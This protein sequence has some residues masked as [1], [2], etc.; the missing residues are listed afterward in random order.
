MKA[1]S[2]GT[3]ESITL[4]NKPKVYV[5]FEKTTFQKINPPY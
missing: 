5:A 4:E 2:F 1:K 3:V